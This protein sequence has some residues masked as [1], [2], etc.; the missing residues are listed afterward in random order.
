MKANVYTKET[1]AHVHFHTKNPVLAEDF[2]KQD[3]DV[4]HLQVFES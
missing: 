1:D 2:M 4:E 3:M